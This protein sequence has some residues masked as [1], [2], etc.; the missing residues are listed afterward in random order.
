MNLE[1]RKKAIDRLTNC[2]PLEAS[3][4]IQEIELYDQENAQEVID[5]ITEE[6]KGSGGLTE[7][8]VKP[9]V[10]SLVDGI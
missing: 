8:V 6:M 4:I 9:V 10:Y 5:R 7:T 3:K 2:S 1:E